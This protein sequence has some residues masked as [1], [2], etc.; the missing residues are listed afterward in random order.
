MGPGGMGGAETPP[1]TSGGVAGMG[2]YHLAV[3]QV[4][5]GTA[6]SPASFLP[7]APLFNPSEPPTIPLYFKDLWVAPER[8]PGDLRPL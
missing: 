7:C 3:L 5:P 6:P 2:G 1:P 8:Q 4:L